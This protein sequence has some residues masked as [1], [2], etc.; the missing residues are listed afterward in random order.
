MFCIKCGEKHPQEAMFCSKCGNKIAAPNTNQAQENDNIS[1]VMSKSE[2]A[3]DTS[4]EQKNSGAYARVSHAKANEVYA[5]HLA[6]DVN[7]QQITYN[8]PDRDSNSF[9]HER[10]DVYIYKSWKLKNTCSL[11][12]HSV[13]VD[14][15]CCKH[16]LN[17]CMIIVT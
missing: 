10:W 8:E 9:I 5:Q 3:K 12:T 11:I 4:A 15:V 6:G 7:T 17:C 1:T 2:E 13:D 14:S 16:L